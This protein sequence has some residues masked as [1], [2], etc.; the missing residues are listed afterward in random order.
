MGFLSVKK[1]IAEVEKDSGS[2]DLTAG[3]TV[4]D[5]TLRRRSSRD[6]TPS[7][8]Q[9]A[10]KKRPQQWKP[11]NETKKKT[12]PP[13]TSRAGSKQRGLAV[14]SDEYKFKEST[15]Q[16]ELKKLG[17]GFKDSSAND[18]A[19]GVETSSTWVLVSR[20]FGGGNK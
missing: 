9:V 8:R 3:M 14:V 17:D 1:K 4:N 2:K 10:M 20:I 16:L 15:P 19:D 7:L 5:D 11:L 18:S 13:A 12:T 6:S